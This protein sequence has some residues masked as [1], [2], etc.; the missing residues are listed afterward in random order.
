MTVSLTGGGAVAKQKMV[1][2]DDES[3]VGSEAKCE[4]STTPEDGTSKCLL[5]YG[6]SGGSKRQ[7]Q[8]VGNEMWLLDTGA[9]GRF[10]HD[11]AKFVGYAECNVILCFCGRR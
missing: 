7:T 8:R 2:I 9:S 6:D 3:A 11:S 1:K 10:T 4:A 5:S